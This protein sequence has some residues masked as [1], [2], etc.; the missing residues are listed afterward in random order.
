MYLGGNISTNDGSGK[1]IERR[2]GLARGMLQALNRIWTSKELSKQTKMR[3][4]IPKIAF[5]GYVHHP[6]TEKERKAK[7]K[8]GMTVNSAAR[9]SSDRDCWRKSI[10]ELLLRALA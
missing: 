9:K 5:N 2:I 10:E 3:V 7:E 8:M 6:R 4:M 1:D